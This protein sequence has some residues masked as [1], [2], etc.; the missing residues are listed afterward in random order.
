VA[1]LRGLTRRCP[2]CGQDNLFPAWFRM[3]ERC[4]RCGLRFERDEGSRLGS[5]MLNYGLV[6]VLLVVYLL[7]SV[8]L[9][10]PEPPL[11][12]LLIGAVAVVVIPA[13]LFFPFAKTLWSAVELILHGFRLDEDER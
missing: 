13:V 7:V 8:A 9:T 6:A 3:V 4:P 12:P 5:A 10:L 2:R 1:V 11:V